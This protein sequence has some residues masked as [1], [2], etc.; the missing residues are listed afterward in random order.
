M[1]LNNKQRQEL[2]VKV[3]EG[4]QDWHQRAT[5]R[6]TSPETQPGPIDQYC[7]FWSLFTVCYLKTMFNINAQIQAGTAYWPIREIHLDQPDPLPDAPD[8]Y[9]YEFTWSAAALE[10]LQ[11]GGQPEMHVWAAI[12]KPPYEI[13]DLTAPFFRERAE[14][15]GYTCSG[16]RP[17]AYFWH[18]LTDANPLPLGVVYRT[19]EQAIEIA[20]AMLGTALSNKP[21]AF[22]MLRP[23]EEVS[24]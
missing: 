3:H 21:L 8:Q 6:A 22:R 24:A 13:I 18:V 2:V 11:S 17:P 19:D 14:R 7:L 16:P 9:G 1:R 10:M 5:L 15:E 20:Y 23:L 4:M 12:T